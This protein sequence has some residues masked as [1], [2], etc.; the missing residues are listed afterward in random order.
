VTHEFLYLCP[1]SLLGSDSLTKLG[2]Q[3]T[4]NQGGPTNLTM[5]G[6]NTLIM[7][8]TRH[9]EDEWQLHQQEKWDLEKPICLLEEFPDVWTE[10]GAPQPCTHT[11]GIQAWG[12]SCQ[13]EAVSS[14]TESIP[15]NSDPPTE[16]EGCRDIN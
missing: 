12:S 5:R 16:A 13:T 9:T 8:V 2:T 10:N 14:T 1:I 4:F 15:R 3:I 6:P 7:A 11:G